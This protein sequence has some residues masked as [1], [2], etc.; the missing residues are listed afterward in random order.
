M[1]LTDLKEV[2][3]SVV[4]EDYSRFS[5]DDKTIIRAKIVVKKI[6]LSITKTP[7]G[8]PLQTNFDAVNIVSAKVPETLRKEPSKEPI[9]F[10]LDKG[11]E[12]SI[13]SEDIKEQ[14]YHTEDGLKIR[15]KP[16]VTKAFRY[17]KYDTFGY[18]IYNVMVQPI[19]TIDKIQSTTT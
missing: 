4:M 12:K 1:S 11:E 7:E 15:I 6:M 18:P 14:E 16:I 3:F 2:D 13:I 9:D 5:L 17:E 19:T 8:Y 10:K